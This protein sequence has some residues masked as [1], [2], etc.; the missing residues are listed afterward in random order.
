MYLIIAELGSQWTREHEKTRLMGRWG[1]S[2]LQIEVCFS[3]ISERQAWPKTGN[4][5]TT[6]VTATCCCE[7]AAAP[8]Q[9]N[10]LMQRFDRSA[11]R[12]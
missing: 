5:L 6:V 10:L 7:I 4:A 1:S 11:D 3:N 8:M 12:V 2:W 9:G